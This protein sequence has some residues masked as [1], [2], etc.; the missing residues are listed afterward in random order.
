MTAFP[1]LDRIGQI[2]LEA[3]D[4]EAAVQ[5]YRD[6]L[7][8]THLFTTPGPAPMAFFSD[9]WANTLALME[10]RAPETLG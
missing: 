8:M 9:P 2:A 7:G 5:F 6:R 3:A 10:E 1:G 4:V